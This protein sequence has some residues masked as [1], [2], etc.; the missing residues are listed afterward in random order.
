[1]ALARP[2][3]LIRMTLDTI[4]HY[5]LPDKEPFQ[6]LYDLP[7]KQRQ[8][9]IDELNKR[10]HNGKANRGYPDWYF[11]QREEAEE[12]L[13][14]AFKAKGQ[15]PERQ[16]PHYFTLGK[17]IAFEWL[18]KDN[19]HTVEIPVEACKSELLFSIGDT[20]WT[21]ANSRNPEVKWTNKWYQGQLYNHKE[22]LEII[23]EIGVDM[24]SHQSINE[25]QIF[26]IET[27]IWSDNELK[28]LT[29]TKY[30]KT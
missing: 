11:P 19:F 16:S 10:K 27:F 28:E 4:V 7:E 1:M 17:S 9:V 26:C 2:L 20:L 14:K 21:F 13:R 12:A 25:H 3:Y 5:Y 6:N 15:T 23:R 30:N 29:K 22:T 24:N 18:Y 8:G